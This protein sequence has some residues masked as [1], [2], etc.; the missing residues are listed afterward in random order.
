MLKLRSISV[1]LVLTIS[2]AVALACASLAVFSISQQRE[3]TRMALDQELKLQYEGVIAVLEYEGRAARAVSATMAATPPLADAVAKGDRDGVMAMLGGSH[4]AIKALGINLV[5]LTLPPATLFLRVHD[6][7][8]FGDDVSARR[9]TVVAA[10]ATGSPIVGV[11]RARHTL[12]VFA[13]TPVMREGKSQFVVDVGM[14]FGKEFVD[15]IKGRLGVD[16]AIHAF[17]GG[18][19]S[20]LA[21]TFKEGTTASADQIKRVFDGTPLRHDAEIA[22]HPAAVYLGQIRNYAGEPVAVLELAKDS[23]EYEIANANAWRKMML[24][25][26]VVL[27]VAGL[28]AF[29]LGR[30]LTR[31]VAALTQTMNRLSGGDTEIEITGR[32]RADELGTMANAVEVFRKS[33]IEADRLRAAQAQADKIAQ[34]QRRADLHR[35]ADEFEASVGE[36]IRAVSSA[37]TEMEASAGTMNQTAENTGRLSNVVTSASEEASM[38]VQSVASASEELSA[39]IDEI[40]RQVEQ[41]TTIAGEAVRQ[42]QSTDGRINDLSKAADR[43]GNVISLITTIAE[44][45]NLLALNATIEAARAGEAGRGFAVVASEVKTLASQTAKATS[46]ISVQISDMQ[47]AT[48]ESVSAI[49]GIGD[50]IGRISEVASAIAAAVQEQGTATEE[51]SRSIQQAAQGTTQVAVS[52]VEVNKG[53]AETGAVSTQMLSS[54]RTLAN[55]S[56]RLTRQMDKFL[57]TVRAA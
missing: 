15:R 50:T 49:K 42:A 46:E 17:E 51:I 6:P 54:A 10:N 31:P 14:E 53:A 43:I 44:Q 1:R 47:S 33:M 5:N 35:L 21:A 19:F 2:F 20:T 3:L 41:S 29:F 55:E 16:V 28:L 8:A 9:K 37:A 23:T 22:G 11:E 13:M 52:I 24:G 36:I 4:A 26:A 18:T 7:K 48:Q 56:N 27:L 32:D 57:S 25:T 40:G 12:A 45:T 30:S 39:S 38:N 34:E